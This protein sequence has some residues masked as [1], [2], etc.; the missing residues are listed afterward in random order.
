MSQ[1][2][3]QRMNCTTT[4]V[5]CV[6]N[7]YNH[8]KAKVFDHGIKLCRKVTIVNGL[9]QNPAEAIPAANMNLAARTSNAEG[10]LLL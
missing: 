7:K 10:K 6:K 5:D 1:E 3:Q 8:A 9:E 4:E 2:W